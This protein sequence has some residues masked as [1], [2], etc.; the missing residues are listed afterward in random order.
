M[1]WTRARLKRTCASFGSFL[2][3]A[4][5]FLASRSTGTLT[6]SGI[7]Y[8]LCPISGGK[9]KT[10]TENAKTIREAENL[11]L[12]IVIFSYRA[13]ASR[14]TGSRNRQQDEYYPE[15]VLCNPSQS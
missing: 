12:F 1:A 14:L 3:I 9:V 10:S 11:V 8:L 13:E 5:R 2:A 7:T 15:P 4:S 6:R